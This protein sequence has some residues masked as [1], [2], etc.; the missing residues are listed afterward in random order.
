MGM[1]K[2]IL[3]NLKHGEAIAYS[4]CCVATFGPMFVEPELLPKSY[5]KSIENMAQF[6]YGE[7]QVSSAHRIVS[8]IPYRKQ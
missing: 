7:R 5:F 3:P 4:L 2:G 8:N 6:T 1:E